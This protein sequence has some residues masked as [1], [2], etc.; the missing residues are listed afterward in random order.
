MLA[1]KVIGTIEDFADVFR[2]FCDKLSVDPGLLT[3]ETFMEFCNTAGIRYSSRY[4][5]LLND[6]KMMHALTCYLKTPQIR[7]LTSNISVPVFADSLALIV[8]DRPLPHLEFLIRNTIHKLPPRYCHVVVCTAHS[9]QAMKDLCSSIH[10]NI[11]VI[12]SGLDSITQDSYNNLLLSKE[13]WEQ[14]TQENILVYQQD[15]AIF[16]PGIQQF[17]HYDYIGAPWPAG[18]DD[19]VYGVGN[20]GIAFRHR[21]TMLK[22]LDTM[23]PGQLPLGR[24]TLN[25]MS[26]T[27][28]KYP[29]EDV[30]YTRCMLNYNLGNVA[31]RGIAN[32]FSQETIYHKNPFAGH[33][34][35][36]AHLDID[37]ERNGNILVIDDNIPDATSGQGFNR[38]KTVLEI[39]S[40]SFHVT[41]FPSNYTDK[42]SHKLR[43]YQ[44]LGVT[45]QIAKR[46]EHGMEIFDIIS[47]H[48]KS[49]PDFYDII[50]FSRPHN[51]GYIHET[52]RQHSP[53]SKILYDAEALFYKRVRLQFQS[54]GKISL[55]P[56]CEEPSWEVCKAEK[57]KELQML[58]KTDNV[59]VVSENERDAI[60]KHIPKLSGKIV[61]YGHPILPD[62]TPARW[63]RRKDLF[64]LG[65]FVEDDTPNTDAIIYFVQNIFPLVRE[66]LDCR[67]IVGGIEPTE[68]VLKLASD[69]VVV[70]GYIKDTREYYNNC[71]LFIAP[72]R[73]AGGI[74]WKLSEALSYGLPAIISPLLASQMNLTDNVVGIGDTPE[75]FAKKIISAYTDRKVWNSYRHNSIKYIT[76]THNPS[77]F[78]DRLTKKL[79]DIINDG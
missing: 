32:Q 61:V 34:Y 17:E 36:L 53:K 52:C 8:E 64:F 14:F 57:Q 3:E 63:A 79:N 16:R 67:L 27:G 1:N 49:N 46:N 69:S 26:A 11:V 20:G 28:L 19:N 25:Y 62:P 24:S 68:S 56:P 4:Q 48:I 9:L 66:K 37:K 2:Q 72:H 55:W 39:L 59:I 70:K 60:V 35:W 44:D 43:H 15:T 6:M 76:E 18:A 47:D 71:K 10:E 12:D 54:T 33:Q 45:V 73:Y 7:E 29:P 74:P 58:A 51:F 65:S 75:S 38:A 78:R 23:P 31:P 5:M 22:C 50:Y 42:D 77:I 41:L 13:F 30:Y 21:S 40:C